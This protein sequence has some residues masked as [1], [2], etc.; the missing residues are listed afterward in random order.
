MPSKS[1]QSFRDRA[2]RMVVDRMEVDEGL[3][4]YQAMKDIAPKLN[5]SRGSL[6]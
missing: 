2:I 5:V 4:Q 6:R 3:T 1:P